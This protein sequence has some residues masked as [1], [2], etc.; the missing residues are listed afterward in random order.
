VIEDQDIQERS[1][2]EGGPGEV[3]DDELQSEQN[4]TS[5][6][7]ALVVFLVYLVVAFFVLLRIGGDRWFSGDEWGF[8]EGRELTSIDGLFREQ[9]AHWSTVPIVAYRV[10][11]KLFGLRTYLPYMG[12]TIVLHL[13]LAGLLR[14]VMRRSGVGPWVAT[15]VAGT[16]VLFGVGHENILLGVQ[17]SMV[18]SL[19]FGVGQMLLS[20][21]DGPFDRRDLL[22][23]GCGLL[24]I[25]SSTIGIPMV[26][27]VGVA[28]LL[29]RGW[30]MALAQTVPLAAITGV[31]LLWHVTTGGLGPNTDMGTRDPLELARWFGSTVSGMFIGLGTYPVVAVLIVALLLVGLWL[32][33]VGRPWRELRT[34]AS[35]PIALL[36]GGAVLLLLIAAQRAGLSQE[37]GMDLSR[38]SRYVAMGVALTLPALGVAAAE[39]IRR[40]AFMAPVVVVLLLIG[41]PGNLQAFEDGNNA[42]GPGFWAS[43]RRFVVGVAQSELAEDV[44]PDVHPDPFVATTNNL[45][46]GFLRHARKTGKLPEIDPLTPAEQASIDLRLTIAQSAWR[47]PEPAST[48]TTHDQP[49][50]IEADKGEQF[51]TPDPVLISM[52]DD[53]GAYVFPGFYGTPYS[54]RTITIQVP[55]TTIRVSPMP[56][57]TSFDFCT[58]P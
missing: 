50:E 21:H 23:L 11:Y 6:R 29:R 14:V 7:L 10:L 51:V 18:G 56:P 35:M 13:T 12:T 24:A 45:T 58:V 17:I 2:E 47:D 30:R 57:A 42:L 55:D 22:A 48:C 49:I 8:I 39:L 28:V 46:V 43:Q 25:M 16:F 20:D 41:V 32:A 26:F 40:W 31:W 19:V 44:S 4:A 54:G 27:A 33:W 52:Q 36:V 37:L 3:A 38:S 1:T 9:N 15:F 34:I 53:N 5:A